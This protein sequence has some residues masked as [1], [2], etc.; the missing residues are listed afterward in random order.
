MR[1]RNTGRSKHA[2]LAEGEDAVVHDVAWLA[3]RLLELLLERCGRVQEVNLA[4][5]FRGGHLCS[6]KACTVVDYGSAPSYSI[7]TNTD[8]F[9]KDRISVPESELLSLPDPDPLVRITDPDLPPS[10]KSSMKNL[11]FY[12]F[13]TSL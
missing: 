2:N 12:Y 4:V 7:L 10:S 13:V 6:G 9:S 1:I 3:E 11:D 8:R 5:L